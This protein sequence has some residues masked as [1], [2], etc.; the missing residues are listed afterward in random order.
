MAEFMTLTMRLLTVKLGA[1]VNVAHG[2]VRTSIHWIVEVCLY[3]L[4]TMV[5]VAD[6]YPLSKFSQTILCSLT[7]SPVDSFQTLLTYIMIG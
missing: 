6:I 3:I 2:I 5:F 1:N 7:N 4:F